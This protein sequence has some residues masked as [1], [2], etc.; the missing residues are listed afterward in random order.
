M[1]TRAAFS[2]SRTDFAD[3]ALKRWWQDSYYAGDLVRNTFFQ[4][5]EWNRLWNEYYIRGD[6]RRELVLL[7]IEQEGRI[8]AAVPLFLQKR[9]AG[10]V[11]VWRYFLWIADRLSQYP[12]MIMTDTDA[13]AIWGTVT[14]YLHRE[15]ADAWL[16][17]HDVLPESTVSAFAAQGSIDSTGEPYLRIALDPDNHE[18]FLH[19]C[20][21]HMQREIQRTRRLVERNSQLRWNAFQAPEENLVEQLITLNLQRFGSASWFADDRS[22]PFFRS[23]CSHIDKE[24]LLSVITEDDSPVHIMASYLHGDSANYVLSGMDDRAKRWSPGTMNIDNTIRWATQKGY[25]YFDFL[26]GDE[27]YK[28]EFMPEERTSVHRTFPA[29]SGRVRFL[30]ASAVQRGR[31]A[32]DNT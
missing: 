13:A 27:G 10:P 12:D 15:F 9:N 16:T 31:K 26:R 21:P 6:V 30:L 32:L 3:V 11:R 8:V 25:R 19:R 23:L 14:E 20:V 1:D 29:A 4:S 18:A 2:V 22:A 17:L 5:W 7:R 28:R 24:L